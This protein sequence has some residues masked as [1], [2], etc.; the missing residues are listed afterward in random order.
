MYFWFSVQ[1]KGHPLQGFAAKNILIQET[2]MV[3]MGVFVTLM[4]VI[5]VALL[6]YL[7]LKFVFHAVRLNIKS[8][9]IPEL[10]IEVPESTTVGSLKVSSLNFYVLS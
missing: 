4:S 3:L 1:N 8:F 7:T 10:F 9:K 6:N 5:F 2:L